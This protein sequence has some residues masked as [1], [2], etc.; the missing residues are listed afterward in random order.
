[1]TAEQLKKVTDDI[2][3][4]INSNGV[5]RRYNIYETPDQDGVM[6]ERFGLSVRFDNSQF[7]DKIVKL[8]NPKSK[9][10][11]ASGLLGSLQSE[12]NAGNVQ[13]IQVRIA[14]ESYNLIGTRLADDKD[15]LSKKDTLL[16]GLVLAPINNS[17]EEIAKAIAEYRNR[18]SKKTTEKPVE[19]AVAGFNW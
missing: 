12:G 4:M 14:N 13:H 16:F 3:S 7:T 17:D 19:T 6:T 9:S 1:M 5:S 11:E 15:N 18:L 8:G 10:R 2:Q